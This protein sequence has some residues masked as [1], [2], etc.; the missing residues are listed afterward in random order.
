M[1]R[2]PAVRRLQGLHSIRL[3][4]LDRT[5]SEVPKRKKRRK[6]RKINHFEPEHT[7]KKGKS[8]KAGL[9]WPGRLSF[10]GRNYRFST[11]RAGQ[12]ANARSPPHVFH[13]RASESPFAAALA[14]G[15]SCLAGFFMRRD[16]PVA[17]CL[18]LAGL[19]QKSSFLSTP[20]LWS[21]IST[22]KRLE[23]CSFSFLF[24]PCA[25]KSTIGGRFRRDGMKCVWRRMEPRGVVQVKC[26]EASVRRKEL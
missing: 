15:V 7:K 5:R 22:V 11:A 9:A 8:A 6:S 26:T 16:S 1:Q 25:L 18:P 21:S 14:S 12:S 20:S 24:S 17:V 10:D 13:K 23:S 19:P 2:A 3:H 4:Q